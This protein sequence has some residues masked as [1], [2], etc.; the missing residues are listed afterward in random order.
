MHDTHITRYY[1]DQFDG[2]LL[3]KG[4]ERAEGAQGKLQSSPKFLIIHITWSIN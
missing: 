2:A 3:S 1:V 4:A